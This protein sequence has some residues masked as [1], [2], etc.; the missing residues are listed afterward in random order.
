MVK[1]AAKASVLHHWSGERKK[2]YSACSN[3]SFYH[4]A[5][6]VFCSELFSTLLKFQMRVKTPSI[7]GCFFFCLVLFFFFTTNHI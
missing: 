2:K 4:F 3:Q 6:S 1:H 5:I 7:S